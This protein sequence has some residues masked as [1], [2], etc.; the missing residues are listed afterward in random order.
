MNT[1]VLTSYCCVLRIQGQSKVKSLLFTEAFSLL[2]QKGL[3]L[4]FAYLD[5]NVE[6]GESAHCQTYYY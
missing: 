4:V 2:E 6:K 1:H 5:T 3:P